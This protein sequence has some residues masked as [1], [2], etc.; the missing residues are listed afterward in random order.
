MKKDRLVITISDV[1]SSKSYNVNKIIKKY[2]FWFL[3]IVFV[4]VGISSFTISE[5][6]TSVNELSKQSK[7]LQDENSVY[8]SSIDSKIKQIKELGSELEKIE[9]IIGIDTDDTTSLIQ[10]ATLAK[11]TS[12]EKSYMLQTIPN[13]CP[14]KECKTT[15]KFGWRTNPV[16]QKRQYH[17]GID[18]R[19][20][21]R[22]TVYST[23]D[24]VVRYVQDKNEG[25][26]GRVIIISHNFG[27]ETL[28]GHL[29]FTDVKVGDVIKK[30][31]AIARS[32]NSGRSNGPHLHYEVIHA[33]KVLDPI[34][35]IKWNMKNYEEIFEKQRRVEW[36]SLVKL[37]SNQNNKL[38]Q[39]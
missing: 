13:N 14:L 8:S 36:E 26:F 21:R 12:S 4:F 16:T 10:R 17:K 2:I 29:R 32:G 3:L 15:S 5:L 24:G 39:Q 27:F 30:G 1:N 33:S 11:L 6:S 20:A 31:Q 37:I 19:A 38:E 7:I 34:H 35:F 18:L 22:T 25:T 9:S 23:A 28:Y